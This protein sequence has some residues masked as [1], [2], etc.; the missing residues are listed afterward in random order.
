MVLNLGKSGETSPFLFPVLASG[1]LRKGQA[2]D[3]DG[4]QGL[5]SEGCVLNF[6]PGTKEL[7]GHNFAI[8]LGQ[9][10]PEVSRQDVCINL[11]EEVVQVISMNKDLWGRE[12]GN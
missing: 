11:L 9:R 7:L 3:T 1:R 4:C 2:A 5:S 8:I 12:Q 10:T 6:N